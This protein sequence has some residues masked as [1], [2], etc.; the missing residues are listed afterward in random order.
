MGNGGSSL[1]CRCTA[2]TEMNEWS[3]N[4]RPGCERARGKRWRVRE[5][6]WMDGWMDGGWSE[7]HRRVRVRVRLVVVLLQVT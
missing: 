6:G 4:D 1:E 7:R 2:R 3:G 5:G